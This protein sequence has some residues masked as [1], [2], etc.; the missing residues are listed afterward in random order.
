MLI[1]AGRSL[2]DGTPLQTG[3]SY[4]PEEDSWTPIST[5]GAPPPSA[6]H[7]AVWSGSEMLVW[8][9]WDAANRPMQTGGRYDPISKTWSPTTLLNAPHP[10]FFNAPHPSI[11]TG[12]AMFI[13]GGFDYPTSLNSAHLYYPESVIGALEELLR[14]LDSLDLPR[15]TKR[16]LLASLEAALDS[17]ERGHEKSAANQL[18]A[19]QRKVEAQLRSEPELARSLIDAAQ[20]IIDRLDTQRDDRDH[21]DDDDREEDDD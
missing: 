1:W 20:A 8:G 7:A 14:V 2:P 18:E 4:D 6:G 15:K 17:L 21:D 16:P 9:G 12:Q 19:F 11:W 13:Y 5:R 10:R 3:A